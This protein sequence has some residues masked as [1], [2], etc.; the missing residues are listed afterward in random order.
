[1]I[2]T[3]Q[4]TINDVSVKDGILTTS[5]E[6]IRKVVRRIERELAQIGRCRGR[7]RAGGVVVYI[8]WSPVPLLIFTNFSKSL[9]LSPQHC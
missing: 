7:G 6:Q 4:D 2:E 9:A 1:M 5:Q 3:K 8:Y